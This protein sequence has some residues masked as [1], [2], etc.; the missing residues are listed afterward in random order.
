MFLSFPFDSQRQGQLLQG[1]CLL[2]MVDFVNLPPR[3]REPKLCKDLSKNLTSNTI[4]SM[5]EVSKDIFLHLYKSKMSDEFFVVYEI[6]VMRYCK[7]LHL[8]LDFEGS[9]NIAL[10][11]YQ[12]NKES[13]IGNVITSWNKKDD[14]EEESMKLE[15]TVPPYQRV[16]FGHVQLVDPARRAMLRYKYSWNECEVISDDDIRK[17][18]V[19][20]EKRLR[21]QMRSAGRILPAHTPSDHFS[22]SL[23]ASDIKDIFSKHR[24]EALISFIDLSF[25]P[26]PSSI[27]PTEASIPPIETGFPVMWNRPKYN[28]FSQADSKS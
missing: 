3:D 5:I 20:M 4:K 24:D 18:A 13:T 28:L 9:K 25:P 17:T 7:G 14:K 12:N 23:T 26:L 11:S 16:K 15:V 21:R 6:E 2:I 22:N 1:L 10:S 19:E 8:V 27:L